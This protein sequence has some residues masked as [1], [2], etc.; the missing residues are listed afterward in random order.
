[1]LWLQ[2]NFNVT[3]TQ[4]LHPD[5]LL[6]FSAPLFPFLFSFLILPSSYIMY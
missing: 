4:T 1:L 5:I 6:P 2:L 3:L